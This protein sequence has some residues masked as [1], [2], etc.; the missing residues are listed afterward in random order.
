MGEF[1]NPSSHRTVDFNDPIEA[2]ETIQF[3]DLLLW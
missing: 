2:A 1:K 3:A